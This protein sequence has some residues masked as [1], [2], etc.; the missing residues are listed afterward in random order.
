MGEDTGQ[1]PWVLLTLNQ[2]QSP[3]E[4]FLVKHKNFLHIRDM[5][6]ISGVFTD[7][8]EKSVASSSC[9]TF[10]E[11]ACLVLISSFSSSKLRLL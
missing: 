4:L 10:A 6:R 5:V 7:D 11:R 2:Q 9:G 1:S 8:T 3:V